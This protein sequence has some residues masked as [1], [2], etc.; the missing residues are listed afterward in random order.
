[1]SGKYPDAFYRVSVKA[2]IRNSIGE[3]LVVRENGGDMSLIGG[4]MDHHE[5]PHEA[6]VRELYEEA[7]ITA[8][9]TETLYTTEKVYVPEHEAWVLWLVYTIT[10]EADFSYGVGP[11]ADEVAFVDPAS[12]Q[13]STSLGEQLTYKVCCI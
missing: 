5:T 11:D 8:P 1:M 9:F 3:V 6:L 13:G 12:F 2:I 4:G 7:L 10:I